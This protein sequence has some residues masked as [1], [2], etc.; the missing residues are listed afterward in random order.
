M[1]R[2][3]YERCDGRNVRPEREGVGYKI[4][5]SK[6]GVVIDVAIGSGLTYDKTVQHR[7]ERG[8]WSPK[9]NF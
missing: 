8:S 7:W 5:F 3:Y 2:K 6:L 9:T 1:L 4:F